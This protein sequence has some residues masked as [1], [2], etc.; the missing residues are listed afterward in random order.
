MENT[1]ALKDCL[2]LAALADQLGLYAYADSVSEQLSIRTAAPITLQRIAIA[3]DSP[4]YTLGISPQSTYEQAEKAYFDLLDHFAKVK[5][6]KTRV[7]D[8][9]IKQINEAF[10]RISKN[11]FS[12]DEN[13]QP[14]MN[15]NSIEYQRRFFHPDFKTKERVEV[16]P[17]ENSIEEKSP[18]WKRWLTGS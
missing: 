14:V 3:I 12:M 2:E 18:W 9:M 5:R 7:E 8:F 4:F 16:P 13:N 15:E 1:S 6:E 10:K 17:S 11:E